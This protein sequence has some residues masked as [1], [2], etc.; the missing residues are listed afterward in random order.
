M[1]EDNKEDILRSRI[2]YT[3]LSLVSEKI[4]VLI[5]GGGR[6]ALIKARTFAKNGCRVW[7]ISKK[8]LPEFYQ[9]SISSNLKLVNEEYS[10]KHV[11]DKHLIIIAT[12]N[13]DTNEEI[14]NH[15]DELYKLYIDCSIPKKGL[16]IT[17]C[18][19][20]TKST[21]FGIN[22]KDFSPKTSVFLAN[23]IKNKLEK[24]DDFIAFTAFIRNN[25]KD[26]ANKNEIMDFICSEDFLF[27]YDKG[28]EK[29]ILK[30][31]YPNIQLLKE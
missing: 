8:F 10:K 27:F 3:M 4:S 19:R 14:R 25:I 16:C 17:S 26:L 1:Y 2:D 11:I 21:T 28:M 24:Y 12:N 22:T 20:S 29:S 7:V 5:V 6:A 18:Q 9:L 13:E 30:M 15:C 23:R 31:F